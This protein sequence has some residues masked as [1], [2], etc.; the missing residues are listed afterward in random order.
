L[1]IGYVILNL[2]PQFILRGGAVVARWAHNPKVAGSNPASAT[3]G[4]PWRES[5]GAFLFSARAE[6]AH[7]RDRNKKGLATRSTACFFFV[8]HPRNGS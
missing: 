3:P 6:L 7:A 5:A 4:K 2:H 8:K 1:V